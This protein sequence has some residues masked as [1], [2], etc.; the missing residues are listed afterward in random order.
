MPTISQFYGIL[1]QMY[2]N[3]KH[4]PHFH[5]IY[6]GHRAVFSINGELI[7]GKLPNRARRLV[8][9]WAKQHRAELLA[10][11]KRACSGEPLQD[12]E[13]LE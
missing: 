6:N 3:D 10:N 2:F 5:A 7:E 13:P 8:T 1:I 11:W 12:I 9:L 4:H